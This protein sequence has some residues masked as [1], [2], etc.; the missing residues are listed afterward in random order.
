MSN[1][2]VNL[3]SVFSDNSVLGNQP[4]VTNSK[5]RYFTYQSQYTLDQ[6]EKNGFYA[7]EPCN[8][9]LIEG[10]ICHVLGDKGIVYY[11]VYEELKSLDDVYNP[12]IGEHL[13]ELNPEFLPSD[14]VEMP[15]NIFGL[16][17]FKLDTLYNCLSEKLG[18][19][20]SAEDWDKA[21]VENGFTK[22]LYFKEYP[23]DEQKYKFGIMSKLTKEMIKK[24]HY[25]Y[26]DGSINK[27]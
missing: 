19:N 2:S 10:E 13:I 27:L 5:L 1:K 7:N 24:V 18:L 14:R 8:D 21:L 11:S 12:C 16:I 3:S 26:W 15:R 22:E 17:D 23:F 9:M 25:N 20:I 4:S 6:I